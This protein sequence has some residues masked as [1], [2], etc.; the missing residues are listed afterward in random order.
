MRAQSYTRYAHRFT[1][2]TDVSKNDL[3]CSVAGGGGEGFSVQG[4]RALRGS[5]EVQGEPRASDR[6]GLS[7]VSRQQVQNRNHGAWLC[8]VPMRNRKIRTTQLH[9]ADVFGSSRC[10]PEFVFCYLSM[11]RRHVGWKPSLIGQKWFVFYFA[12]LF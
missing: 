9:T 12:P 8:P 2:E 3:K 7:Q 10:I 5:R 1:Q 11:S 4:G 6:Q